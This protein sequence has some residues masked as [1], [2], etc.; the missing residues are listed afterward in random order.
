[1]ILFVGRRSLAIGLLIALGALLTVK[2]RPKSA[3][4]AALRAAIAGEGADKTPR[5][6]ILLARLFLFGRRMLAI[7]FLIALGGL[8]ARDSV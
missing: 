4:E 6:G 1:M 7:G 2:L 8:G 5:P 3:G